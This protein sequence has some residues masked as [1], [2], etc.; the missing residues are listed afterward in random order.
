MSLEFRR[1]LSDLKAKLIQ[2]LNTLLKTDVLAACKGNDLDPL[3]KE[4][5]KEVLSI[6]ESL[7]KR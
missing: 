3:Y 2:S 6:A 1:V 7:N 5:R 4:Y